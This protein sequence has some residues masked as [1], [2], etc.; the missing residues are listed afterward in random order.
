VKGIIST[1]MLTLR[2]CLGN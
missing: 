2:Y 1:K